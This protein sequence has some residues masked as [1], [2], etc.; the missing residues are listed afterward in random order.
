LFSIEDQKDVKLLKELSSKLAGIHSMKVPIKNNDYWFLNSFEEY[1]ETAYKRF[2]IN[3][4]IKEYNC[5]TLMN[6]DLKTEIIWIK[7][8]MIESNSPIVFTHNDFRSRNIMKTETNG[9]VFCD[10]DYSSYG[11][12]GIDFGTIFAEW[13]RSLSDFNDI[14][15][16]PEDFTLKPIINNYISESI[17]INGKNYFEN[18][19]NSYEQILYEV[20]V[21]VLADNL[22]CSLIILKNDN[23][24]DEFHF[25]RNVSLV[26]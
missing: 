26:S 8:L 15:T 24:L 16:F 10:F 14:Q 11:Y 25:D 12:R 4:L 23:N 21:F 19:N 2:P 17:N 22:F 20:K 13:G 5:Q 18:P 3:D 1:Y 9:L 6:N 7:N